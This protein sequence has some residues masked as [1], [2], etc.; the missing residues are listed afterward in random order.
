MSDYSAGPKEAQRGVRQRIIRR[1]MNGAGAVRLLRRCVALASLAA[2]AACAVPSPP[3]SSPAET[4]A[5]AL[6]GSADQMS[7]ARGLLRSD[8]AAAELMLR[9]KLAESPHDARALNDL[10]VA[11]DLLGRHQDAQQTYRQALALQSDMATRL[12]LALSIAISRSGAR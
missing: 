5:R 7:T 8:P 12:N 11:L 3:A 6:S 1:S 10:A 9:H 4:D 2:L